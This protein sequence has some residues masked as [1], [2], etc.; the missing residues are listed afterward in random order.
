MVKEESAASVVNN[1]SCDIW[2]FTDNR[3]YIQF[4]SNWRNTG[5]KTGTDIV[6]KL[7]IYSSNNGIHLQWIPS[8]VDLFFNDLVDKLAMEGSAEPLEV[9]LP[10]VKFSQKSGSM[11]T[12]PEG[13]HLFMTGTNKNIL[14]LP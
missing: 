11:T 4:L 12:G 10:I 14:G 3:S 7:R 8:H 1:S 6:N 2:I 13:S 9:Y 5:D